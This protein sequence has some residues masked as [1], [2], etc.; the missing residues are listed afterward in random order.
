MQSGKERL[1]YAYQKKGSKKA[2]PP[3]GAYEVP[4]AFSQEKRLIE[5]S[6]F[7]SE[8]KRE[9]FDGR[10]MGPNVRMQGGPGKKNFHFNIRD[11]WM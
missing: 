3:V 2:P 11:E 6:A 9:P 5:M 4:S 7:M 10:G 8:C 1:D